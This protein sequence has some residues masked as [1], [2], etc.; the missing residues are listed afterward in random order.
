MGGQ[1]GSITEAAPVH[2]T[3]LAGNPVLYGE[4]HALRDK[5]VCTEIVKL[6]QGPFWVFHEDGYHFQGYGST[7]DHRS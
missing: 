3:L 5:R 2:V 4:R 1:A 6:G 7:M